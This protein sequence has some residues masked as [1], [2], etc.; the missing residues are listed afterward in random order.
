MSRSRDTYPFYEECYTRA[1]E[2]GRPYNKGTGLLESSHY[3]TEFRR[4][5][6]GISEESSGLRGGI[7]WFSV[8]EIDPH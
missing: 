1:S 7:R 8:D 5:V 4:I 6:N 2:A 3:Q